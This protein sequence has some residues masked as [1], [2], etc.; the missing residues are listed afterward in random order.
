MSETPP[1]MI[2]PKKGLSGLAIAGMGCGGLL[3]LFILVAALLVMKACNK[4]KE[5][6]GDFTVNPAKAMAM[7]VLKSNPELDV[8]K[9]DDAKGEI[10]VRNKKSGEVV[11]M[12]FEDI[13]KGKFTMKN[14]KGEEVSID[15][16]D[17]AGK[18]GVVMKGPEG[19]VVI[20]GANTAAVAP[21]A[22]VPVYSNLKAQPGGMRS[23]KNGVIA[24]AFVAETADSGAKVKEF[25]E[26]KLKEAGFEIEVTSTSANG[27]EFN[28]VAG[29][30][31]DGKSKVTAII[32]TENGKTGVML[33]YE[34]KK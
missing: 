19:E 32:T 7:I 23:E 22:W 5:V 20:G 4:V 28:V 11:T 10:T 14:A 15:A 26:A 3:L 21:P 9:T 25:Y 8:V 34:G 2:A 30:K 16:S 29:T 12:S 13:K 1:P 24:G 27:G 18:G 33:N 17:A 6:A 31:D